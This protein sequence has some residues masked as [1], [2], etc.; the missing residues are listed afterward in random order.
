MGKLLVL[1]LII[2]LAFWL[3]RLS[4]RSKKENNPKN[5][6]RDDSNVIDIEPEDK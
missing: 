5:M 6:S 4:A 2:I 1:A 3:G